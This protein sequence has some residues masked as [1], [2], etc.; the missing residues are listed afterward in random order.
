MG[1]YLKGKKH[2]SETI[3]TFSFKIYLQGWGCNSVVEHLL[4]GSRCWVPS[5]AE[6]KKVKKIVYKSLGL[7]SRCFIFQEN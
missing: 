2:T 5:S 7:R 1:D 3:L 4:A 6:G